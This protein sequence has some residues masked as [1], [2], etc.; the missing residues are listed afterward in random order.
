MMSVWTSKYSHFNET[1]HFFLLEGTAI[2][3]EKRFKIYDLFL[4]SYKTGKLGSERYSV[5]DKNVMLE[6]PKQCTH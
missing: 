3:V 5:N 6:L 1:F 4:K 2:P